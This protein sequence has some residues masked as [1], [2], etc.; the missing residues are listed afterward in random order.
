MERYFSLLKGILIL[1]LLCSS[2]INLMDV[3]KEKN[4]GL[5]PSCAIL[6]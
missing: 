5:G 2:F 6:T 3:V 1:E 4:P